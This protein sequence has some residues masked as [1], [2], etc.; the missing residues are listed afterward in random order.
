MQKSYIISCCAECPAFISKN[1]FCE[2][3]EEIVEQDVSN[4]VDVTLIGFPEWC[5]LSDIE[6]VRSSL[7]VELKKISRQI[8]KRLDLDLDDDS[9]TSISH[10][11]STVV[12][13]KDFKG[14]K[15]KA[16]GNDLFSLPASQQL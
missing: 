12:D 7:S 10:Y 14:A 2:K 16:E 3:E 5:P 11:L 8:L 1:N 6:I 13:V 4:P 15:E 9:V